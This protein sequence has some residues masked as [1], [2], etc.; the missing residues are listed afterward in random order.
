[1]AG[2]GP[3][4]KAPAAAAASPNDKGFD[5]GGYDYPA[6]DAAAGDV[7]AAGASFGNRYWAT[8]AAAY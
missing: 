6:G 3:K 7:G 1:M 5:Q 8:A 2:L 4:A